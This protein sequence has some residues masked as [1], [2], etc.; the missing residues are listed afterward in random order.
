MN[1]N[2]EQLMALYEAKRLQALDEKMEEMRHNL[3]GVELLENNGFDVEL[4]E[5]NCRYP[6]VEISKD[7]LKKVKEVLG[8][9]KK[10]SVEPLTDGRSRQVRVTYQSK[11]YPNIFVTYREQLSR[12]GRYRVRTVKRNDY[13]VEKNED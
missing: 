8:E 13:V 4:N 7:E 11:A 10:F 3:N 5:H 2:H 9:M 6:E 12:N 1:R